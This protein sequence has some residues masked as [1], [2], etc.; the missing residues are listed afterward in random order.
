MSSKYLNEV[1]TIKSCLK[2]NLHYP[3]LKCLILYWVT[4]VREKNINV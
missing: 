3:K 1:E 4:D 2:H